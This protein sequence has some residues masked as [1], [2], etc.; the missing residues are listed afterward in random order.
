MKNR[1]HIEAVCSYILDQDHEYENV[2]TSLIEDS[3]DTTTRKE[4]REYARAF[5]WYSAMLLAY[6]KREAEKAVTQAI[7]EAEE[8]K[9]KRC[10]FRD[11]KAYI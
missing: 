3:D 5:T 10:R 7:Q 9:K 4:K 2:V 11:D 8:D 1:E 6:G